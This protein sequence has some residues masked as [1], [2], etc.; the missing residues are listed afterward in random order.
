MPSF[1]FLIPA[2]FA[3]ALCGTPLAASAQSFTDTQR[4]ILAHITE[5][6]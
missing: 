5:R 3:V 4:R 6:A 2:L 1:R